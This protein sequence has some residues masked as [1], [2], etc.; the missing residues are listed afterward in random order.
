VSTLLAGIPC[1][2]PLWDTT[3]TSVT[4][5]TTVT[6]SRHLRAP[7]TAHSASGVPERRALPTFVLLNVDE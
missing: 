7:L 5:V 3:V 2:I 6:P 4:F 1:G